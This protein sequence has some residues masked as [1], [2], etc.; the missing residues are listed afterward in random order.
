MERKLF[1]N[2]IP[3]CLKPLSERKVGFYNFSL[4]DIK[5]RAREIDRKVDTFTDDLG[6]IKGSRNEYGG[7]D[8]RET[9]E[10]QQSEF[11][12]WD[13]KDYLHV[14]RQIQHGVIRPGELPSENVIL[15]ALARKYINDRRYMSE[16]EMV[17]SFKTFK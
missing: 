9:Y 16:E 1:S 17:E 10:Y 3:E 2:F 4:Q 15:D 12:D 5:E 14:K 11:A 8:F 6:F 7:R 13:L